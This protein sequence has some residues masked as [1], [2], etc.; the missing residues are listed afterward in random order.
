MARIKIK[1]LPRNKTMNQEEMKQIKAGGGIGSSG[2]GFGLGFLAKPW[3][4]SGTVAAAI[5]IPLAIS[6]DDDD[7]S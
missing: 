5:A 3:V 7:A 6:N 1:D 2:S 4:L